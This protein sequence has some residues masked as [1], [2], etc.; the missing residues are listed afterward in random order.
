MHCEEICREIVILIEILSIGGNES[1]HC[2]PSASIASW[3]INIC[4]RTQPSY[5]SLLNRKNRIKLWLAIIVKQKSLLFS[6]WHWP[7]TQTAYSR[8]LIT[9]AKTYYSWKLD[10]Y[11]ISCRGKYCKIC[12]TERSEKVR[13]LSIITWFYSRELRPILSVGPTPSSMDCISKLRASPRVFIF[14]KESLRCSSRVSLT[15]HA[16]SQSF[17][18]D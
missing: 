13:Q 5:L 1:P 14:S 18:P 11:A 2:Y 12:P 10:Y 3:C 9:N 15:E 8:L 7:W 17:Y 6:P 16:F 4:P